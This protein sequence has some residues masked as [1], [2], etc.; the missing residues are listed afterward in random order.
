M[1]AARQIG[2]HRIADIVLPQLTRAPAGHIE[3]TVVQRQVDVAD[4]RRHGAEALEQSRQQRRIRGLGWDDRRLLRV[5]LA[6]FAI[7]GPDRAFEVGRVDDHAEEAV[8][9]RRVVRRPQLQRHLMVRAEVDALHMTARAQLPEVD[10]VAIAI[11]QQVLGHDAVLELR[12][13]APFAGHHVVARQV[14]PEVVVQLL[15]PALDLPLAEHLEV[16]AVH[17]EDAGRALGAVGAAPAR[18]A[19]VDAFRAAVHGVRTRVPG[20]AQHL[21][22]LDHFGDGG[23]GRIGLRID[24]VDARRA[25]ARHDQVAPLQEG[26]P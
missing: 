1:H 20:L 26:V 16:L 12:R 4:Q 10:L 22:G 21:F 13:Q 25:D 2:L 24:D 9:P 17:Q 6:A 14:P 7:P 3:K 23:P 18:G 5:E 8:L 15:R 19:D 11:G